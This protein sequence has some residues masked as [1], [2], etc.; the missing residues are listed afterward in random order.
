MCGKR[1]SGGLN[2]WSSTACESSSV[3]LI[4]AR[5]AYDGLKQ[6]KFG[7]EVLKSPKDINKTVHIILEFGV[8]FMNSSNKTDLFFNYDLFV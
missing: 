5:V 2:E 6:D 3:G 1:I 7:T 4:C 8:N